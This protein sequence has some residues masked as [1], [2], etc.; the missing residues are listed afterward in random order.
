MATAQQ[1][2]NWIGIFLPGGFLSKASAEDRLRAHIVIYASLLVGTLGLVGGVHTWIRGEHLST[3][4]SMASAGLW[5]LALPTL[6]LTGSV[7]AAG[8]WIPFASFIDLSLHLTFVWEEPLALALL[9]G[10]PLAAAMVLG[11][12]HGSFW[13]LITVGSV[14]PLATLQAE[15]IGSGP[16]SV[17]TVSWITIA[18]SVSVYGAF[19]LQDRMRT[20]AL[21]K[22][23]ASRRNAEETSRR[24]AAEQLRFRALSEDSFQTITETDRYGVVLYANSR[25][26]EVLGHKPEDVMGLHPAD[27]LMNPPPGE[28]PPVDRMVGSGQR[29]EVENRHRDGHSVWQEVVASRYERPDGEQRWIFAGRD[30]TRER[31]ARAKLQEAAKLESVGLLAGGVAHDFNNLL[32]VISGFAEELDDGEPA[33]AIRNAA[34]SAALLTGQLLDFGRKQVLQPQLLSLDSIVTE[35]RDMLQSLVREEV[36]LRLDLDSDP[37]LVELDPNQLQR[38]LVNLATNARD[39]MPTGGTLELQTRQ[40]ELEDEE[41]QVI[42][43]PPG[44]YAQLTVTDSGRGMEPETRDRAFEPFFTTK[45]VGEGTGL[46]LASVYG[47]VEQSRGGICLTSSPG[48]GTV[49][50]LYFPSKEQGSVPVPGEP[51]RTR[52]ST[53]SAGRRILLVEDEPVLRNLFAESLRRDEHEVLVAASGREALALLSD[54]SFQPDVVVSDVVMPEMRGPDLAMLLRKER[55]DLPVLLLSGYSDSQIG[56][57]AEEGP[58]TAFLAKPFAPRELVAAVRELLDVCEQAGFA[59]Q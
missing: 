48:T 47:I 52:F 20:A 37:Y 8:T 3:G 40:V 54:S 18:F 13:L 56:L 14:V 55:P 49:V 11:A 15:R 51:R 6:A 23:D 34:Q 43:I 27:L 38:V 9:F 46:G 33:E 26:F 42:G 41:A 44:R 59:D 36:R 31:A 53:P 4:I 24:L 12:G 28:K 57:T 30:I 16:M 7:R 29:F 10:V 39:A 45:K 35:A 50:S 58:S 25:F 21:R 22:L 2:A 5:F 17:A 19:A 32:T 1:T